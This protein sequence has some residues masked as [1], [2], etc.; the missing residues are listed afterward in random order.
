MCVVG[1]GHIILPKKKKIKNYKVLHTLWVP[2]RT[3]QTN[4]T[5][6]TKLTEAEKRAQPTIYVENPSTGKMHICQGCKQP[7]VFNGHKQFKKNGWKLKFYCGF[8]TYTWGCD[9]AMYR[10]YGYD[11][12]SWP[13]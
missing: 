7:F 6:S 10:T 3:T 8:G 9:Q 12:N 4:E 13:D 1:K 11:R 2:N 5:M